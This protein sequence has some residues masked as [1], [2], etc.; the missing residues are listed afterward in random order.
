[1]LERWIS[2]SLNAEVRQA[3]N[4]VEALEMIGERAVDLLISD[5]GM[6]VLDGLELQALVRADPSTKDLPVIRS[7]RK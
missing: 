7:P 3:E 4:G 2:R 6:P 1:M 5:I